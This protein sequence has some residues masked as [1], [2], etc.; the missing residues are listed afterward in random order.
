MASTAGGAG[1][2]APEEFDVAEERDWDILL[3]EIEEGEVIP[4]IGQD[5]LRV[6]RN[7]L[8]TDHSQV[9]ASELAEVLGFEPDGEAPSLA[10]VAAQYLQRA[11]SRRSE[12][13][14]SVEWL[15]R[16]MERDD[17]PDALGKLAE[18]TPFRLFVTTT[19]D[20]WM[21]QALTAAGRSVT[22]LAY[23]P[24]EQLSDLPK[25]YDHRKEAFVYHLLGRPG[26]SAFAVT[27]EDILEFMHRL[28][29]PASARRPDQLFDTLEKS[30][31]LF[32]GC[33]FPDWLT[34]FFLRMA[35]GVPLG[36][37]HGRRNW[38]AGGTVHGDSAGGLKQFL[39]T[40]SQRT[41][42]F[43]DPDATAFIANLHRRWTKRHP[44]GLPVEAAPEP[45]ATDKV[46]LSYASE[47]REALRELCKRL[48]EKNVLYW[49]DRDELKA[50]NDWDEKIRRNVRSCCLFVPLISDHVVTDRERY[51]RIEWQEALE[52][53]RM[54]PANGRFVLPVLLEGASWSL[55]EAEQIPLDLQKLN[56]ME[57]GDFLDQVVDFY[58][59]KQRDRLD[60]RGD[61]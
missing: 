50:G 51:F 6:E 1:P 46:F 14:D 53:Q 12:L 60:G 11:G 7:G 9:L 17:H 22:S 3:D 38:I 8:A 56:W 58:R 30:H 44:E 49:F 36:D 25:D 21:E 55:A 54:Q 59:D 31:L 42:I 45:E 23:E 4:I 27:E 5:V 48:D 24:T 29:S 35:R 61:S 16:R 19:F 52:R 33:R 40:S 2:V 39:L 15:V 37:P 34:R 13:Y 32:L 20:P 43:K 10:S 41:K 28:L 47:D 26:T 57:L 18:I